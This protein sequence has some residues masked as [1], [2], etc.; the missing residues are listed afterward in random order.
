MNSRFSCFSLPTGRMTGTRQHTQQTI[1]CFLKLPLEPPCSSLSSRRTSGPTSQPGQL[2]KRQPFFPARD[3]PGN[4]GL[5]SPLPR[6]KWTSSEGVW[7]A[8]RRRCVIRNKGQTRKSLVSVMGIF[9]SSTVS[10]GSTA[11]PCCWITGRRD[12][13]SRRTRS[14]TLGSTF[15]DGGPRGVCRLRWPGSF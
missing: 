6:G 8:A 2:T 7:V 14:G 15:F 4:H 13:C 11:C 5:P 9:N 1:R 10:L 12:R 3:I